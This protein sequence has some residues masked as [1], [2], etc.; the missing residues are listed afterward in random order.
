MKILDENIPFLLDAYSC[1]ILDPKYFKPGYAQYKDLA[2]AACETAEA[3]MNYKYA[4]E[5][6]K[7]FIDSQVAD[8]DITPKLSPSYAA[9]QKWE[10]IIDKNS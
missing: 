6:A 7:A 10:K 2:V 1:S 4:Y 8:S 9:Y 5:A 3:L